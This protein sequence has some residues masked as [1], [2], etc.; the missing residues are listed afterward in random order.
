VNLARHK[1]RAGN[2]TVRLAGQ[3]AFQTVDLKREIIR[4]MTLMPSAFGCVDRC[5]E[6]E[7]TKVFEGD[8]CLR[9][10][11]VVRVDEIKAAS[12]TL[13]IEGGVLQ[14]NVQFL[15][16]RKKH[17]ISNWRDGNAMDMDT[18][19]STLVPTALLELRSDDVNFNADLRQGIGQ[20]G[21]VTS[22]AADDVWRVLPG[23]HQD[24]HSPST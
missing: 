13:H 23:Q 20:I 9:D 12:V 16:E 14:R 3:Q 1:V 6:G 8:A 19:R 7:M 4:Q 2:D 5:Q 21:D 10:E 18:L 11:P 24:T 17:A 22:Q 15:G